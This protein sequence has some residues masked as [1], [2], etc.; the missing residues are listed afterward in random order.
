MEA[1][2]E[3]QYYADWVRVF[4]FFLLIFFHCAMPFVVY[5]WEIKNTD[6]SIGLSRFIWWLHQW[7]LPLLFFI[8][9]AGIS[10]SLKRRSVIS[11]AGERFVRLFIPLVFAM[12]FIIPLQVYYEWMQ[13]GKYHGSYGSFYPSVWKFIPYPDGSLTWS[14]MWFVVYLF[15]Y[16]ILLLP[17]FS[18][19]KINA[20][21]KLKQRVSSALSNPVML[22]LLSLPLILYFFTLYIKYPE[23][24]SLLEDWF[25]FLFSLT[26]VFYGYFLAGNKQFWITCERYRKYYLL[27]G[28]TCIVLLYYFYWWRS[29]LPKKQDGRLYWYGVLN[30]LHIWTLILAILGF[31]KKHLNFS[32]SFLKYST[33]AVYPYYILHQ[34]VIVAFG[35]YIVQWQLPIIIKMVLL[36]LICFFIVGVIYHYIIRPYKLTRILF[37]VKLTDKNERRSNVFQE[38]AS[39]PA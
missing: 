33:K 31:A 16:C 34:T 25:L 35:Y 8:S 15:V 10:F 30:S 28:M 32:N 17:V 3:R 7:R 1:A 22:V 29:E 13:K 4:A 27:I 9:G 18:L 12:L 36:V 21:D 24:Q 11:F 23:Q 26:L 5:G 19:F 14:H 38:K 37:G 6:Q 2:N 39:A 20:L